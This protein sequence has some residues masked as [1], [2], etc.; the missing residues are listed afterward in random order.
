[1]GQ[2]GEGA[3]QRELQCHHAVPAATQDTGSTWDPSQVKVAV[4]A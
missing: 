1:M 4:P 3:E 2:A